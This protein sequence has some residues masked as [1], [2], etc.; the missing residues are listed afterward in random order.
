MPKRKYGHGWD[1]D[2]VAS[3]QEAVEELG[4]LMQLRNSATWHRH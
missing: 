3:E 4:N 1:D 2:G